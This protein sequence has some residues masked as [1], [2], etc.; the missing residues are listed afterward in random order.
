M[1][2]CG[3]EAGNVVQS[4]L[5]IPLLDTV[6]L[7]PLLLHHFWRHELRLEA[8]GK[9]LPGGVRLHMRSLQPLPP[10]QRVVLEPC[11]SSLNGYHRIGDARGL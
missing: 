5:V 3:A 10:P 1:S 11:S 2:G 6:E 8:N 7:A 9:G 4:R